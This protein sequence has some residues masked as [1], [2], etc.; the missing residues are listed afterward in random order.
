MAC[1]R[2][3]GAHL[4]DLNFNSSPLMNGSLLASSPHSSSSSD[5][6]LGIILACVLSLV[7][8]VGACLNILV[9]LGVYGNARLGTTVNK[10][11]IWIC[12]LS[13]L[14][15]TVGILMKT[16]ILANVIQRVVLSQHNEGFCQVISAIPFI[17]SNCI[18]V[19]WTAISVYRLYLVIT[20]A[21]QGGKNRLI[22]SS[23][24][25]RIAQKILPLVACSLGTTTGILMVTWTKSFVLFRECRGSCDNYN[26][27]SDHWAAAFQI[28]VAFIYHIPSG[29]CYA[30]IYCFIKRHQR[31][32]KAKS[33]LAQ[34]G[35]MAMS[36]L[37]VP[38]TQGTRLASVSPDEGESSQVVPEPSDGTEIT[39]LPLPSDGRSRK[40]SVMDTLSLRWSHLRSARGPSPCPMIP[41]DMSDDVFDEQEFTHLS[42]SLRQKRHS[43]IFPMQELNRKAS[44]K[45]NTPRGSLRSHIGQSRLLS[46][47]ASNGNGSSSEPPSL[48]ESNPSPVVKEANKVVEIKTDMT[49]IEATAMWWDNQTKLKK[50]RRRR[51]NIVSAKISVIFLTISVLALL[52]LQF[53]YANFPEKYKDRLKERAFA[54]AFFYDGCLLVVG[55]LMVIY[56]S[57]ELR[58]SI[59][60]KFKTRC[61]E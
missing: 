15:A 30:I 12:C 46:V 11:L 21:R 54:Y 6:S 36:L 52:M 28:A 42:E 58:V 22:H 7:G 8:L 34:P 19:L 27:E 50:L 14:E 18:V 2:E 38:A 55:P 26:E 59:K 23:R 25:S 39:A 4:R 60:K 51:K 61:K 45:I 1:L 29:I 10:L 9:I 20:S 56:G 16:L 49:S 13:L 40:S 57:K 53:G 31:Q 43:N 5:S 3:F 33:S 35:A 44:S 32:N 37:Q 47:S 41:S 48:V 24:A 17:F